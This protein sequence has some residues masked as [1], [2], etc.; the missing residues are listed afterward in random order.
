MKLSSFPGL[1]MAAFCLLLSTAGLRADDW[2]TTDGKVYQNVS[3]VKAEPDAVTIT[4]QDGGA[5]VPLAT[6]PP[7]VQKQFNYDPATA[8][9]AADARAKADAEN[10][11][12]LQ[13]EMAKAQQ[14]RQAQWVAENPNTS[15][16]STDNSSTGTP[17]SAA[18]TTP[19]ST[20]V[21]STG[22]V[23]HSTS[24]LVD[25]NQRL[26]DDHD[27]PNHTSTSYLLKNSSLNP[28]PSDPNRHTTA[29]LLN[30]VSL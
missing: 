11:K 2:K 16:T 29:D 24:D 25:V 26:R 1:A 6:L 23:H 22:P 3:V 19:A 20:P 15:T 7:E 28:D 8:K 14:L 30:T 9:A 5:R 12:A 10:A 18:A 13:A 4:H 21:A 17:A 27:D